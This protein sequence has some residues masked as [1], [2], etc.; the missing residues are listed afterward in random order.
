MVADDESKDDMK[1]ET[2]TNQDPQ[3]EWIDDKKGDSKLLCFHEFLEPKV[4]L[5][6]SYF[7]RSIFALLYFIESKISWQSKFRGDD[8]NMVADDESKVGMKMGTHTDQ[9]PQEEWIDDKK[10]DSKLL[11]F[12]EILEPKVELVQSYFKRSIFALLYFIESK[13]SWQSKFRGDDTNMVAD[14][15]SKDDMKMGTHTDQDPQEEWIDDKKGDSKLLCFH[16]IL[17]PKV[18]LVQSYFKRIFALLSYMDC[19]Q[20]SY[21]IC[22]EDVGL[23]QMAMVCFS[24]CIV[25]LYLK[26]QESSTKTEPHE[27]SDIGDVPKA[28]E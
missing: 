6:Q 23:I 10:G 7:K 3:E 28:K 21:D 17:E 18:E 4:E 5:V 16:E 24:F 26:S 15:E 2:H 20:L 13:I 14:D 9:D 12:H 22:S 8:T 27:G 25:I 1:M 19:F 11:C